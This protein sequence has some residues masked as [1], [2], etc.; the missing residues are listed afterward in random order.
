MAICRAT[1]VSPSPPTDGDRHGFGEALSFL[2]GTAGLRE[3]VVFSSLLT[4]FGMSAG[5]VFPA[6]A[7]RVL[8]GHAATLGWLL[9]SS[10]AGALVGAL[11]CVPLVQNVQRVG[12]LAGGAT[13]WRE[14]SLQ[15]SRSQPGC[16]YR[17]RASCLAAWRSRW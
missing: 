12:L 7:E 10:G 13:I 2:R 5:N 3:L 16:R 4:F 1:G 6:I 17:S 9:S 15:R 11:V 14:H 8:N